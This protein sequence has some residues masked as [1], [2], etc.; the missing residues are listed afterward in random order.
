MSSKY[1]FYLRSQHLN[2]IHNR[3][4]KDSQWYHRGWVFQERTLSRRLLIFSGSQVIWSCEQLQAAETWPCG[5]TSENHI[6]RFE[7]F[8][9][10]R[11]RFNELLNPRTGVSSKHAAWWTFLRDYMDSA[12]LTVRS[13]RLVALQ[14]IATL[15]QNLTGQTYCGGFWLNDELSYSLLW[16]P[17]TGS[18]VKHKLRS[19]PSWS[20]A[21]IDG[22]V[23]LYSDI[24]KN[25]SK[26]LHILGY[27]QLPDKSLLGAKY[28]IDALRVAGRLCPVV[29]VVSHTGNG[30]DRVI[31]AGHKQVVCI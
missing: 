21:A 12:E 17:A 9:V 2:R 14:G 24:Q 31:S 30:C 20:W 28:T 19:T 16:K 3:G 11:S 29:L 4:V 15:V 23:Q 22:P 26:V 6:D 1:S 10:E 25:T 7:S 27:E 5:K 18:L 8:E 13:D